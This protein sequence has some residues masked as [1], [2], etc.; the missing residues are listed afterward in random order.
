MVYCK[1]CL[2]KQR[3]I[4][5]LKEKVASLQAKLRY[6]ERTAQEGPFGSST[7]SS[8]IPVKP[9]SSGCPRSQG[10]GKVGHVGH[11][12]SRLDPAQADRVETIPG[13]EVCPDCGGALEARGHRA[14]TVLDCQPVRVQK[15]VYQLPRQRCTQCH[16]LVT[17][18]PP[19][20][21]PQGL[22][23][24]RLLTYVAVQ[25]YVHGHT[26][27][28]IERQTGL[29]YSSLVDAL[30]QLAAR[31]QEVPKTLL[32]AFRQA[33]VKHADETSWRTEGRN[34]YAWLFCTEDT[35]VYRFRGTRSGRVA[36]EVFGDE[37]LP[38]VLLVDRYPG[39]HRMPCSL[40]YCY[41]HLLR[42]VKDLDKAFPDDPEVHAFVE[43]LVPQLAS[44]ISLRGL[45]LPRQQFLR[46]A[47]KI[48]SSILK[49]VNHPAHHPAV[50][51]MQDLFR[52][53]AERMY[54]W[55]DDPRVP[56][57]NNR[58]ERELRP[59]VIAR[60][61]SF[62][63]QSEAGAKTR[64]TLMTVLHTLRKRAPDV[65]MAFQSAL[66]KLAEQPDADPGKILFGLDSS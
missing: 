29:G 5:E 41:A 30:H 64:E 62:G 2:E 16:K 3:E 27:G 32:E 17:A 26:L 47:A 8:K 58:A 50:Q 60:K 22:Y 35:S 54:H 49:I 52:E 61:I 33:P 15:V 65:A 43:V 6:Q 66:D 59:L 1:Q 31:C 63:S 37:P 21:L 38:G 53:K 14:R 20:V 40:Q 9:N 45:G 39:Y 42:D 12:R 19:G 11:G 34:G 55:A 28:Q 56:A 44:A 13:A 57:D 4:D 18:K 36:R 46:Q 51:T 10:G 25:H 23:S 7:P 24:N 48:K